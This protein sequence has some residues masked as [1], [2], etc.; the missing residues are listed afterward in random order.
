M[1][2]GWSC[3]NPLKYKFFIINF[4]IW[5]SRPRSCLGRVVKFSAMEDCCQYNRYI[6]QGMS[7][8][9][10]TNIR[11]MI[12]LKLMCRPS[13]AFGLALS[14]YGGEMKRQCLPSNWVS[15][16]HLWRGNGTPRS[17]E[18]AVG[19]SGSPHP[20]FERLFQLGFLRCWKLYWSRKK[21]EI[22]MM[23][24]SGIYLWQAELV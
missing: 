5:K 24:T 1:I 10:S 6:R 3:A 14:A 22:M 19:K 4:L 11:T 20:R 16:F 15:E 13:S 18:S 2:I 9:R 7:S 17:W 23:I 21:I 8:F 12:C